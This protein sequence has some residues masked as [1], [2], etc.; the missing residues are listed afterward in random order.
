MMW[1]IL[2]IE[3]MYKPF[4]DI[5]FIIFSVVLCVWWWFNAK[6]AT[7]K[8]YILL[9]GICWFVAGTDHIIGKSFDIP[10]LRGALAFIGLCALIGGIYFFIKVI[11]SERKA[12]KKSQDD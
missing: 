12:K 9:L 3:E 2:E 1:N 4:Y 11:I 8:K 5:G 7:S 10:A 6:E